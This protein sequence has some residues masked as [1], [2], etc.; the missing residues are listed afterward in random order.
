MISI[1]VKIDSRDATKRL[2]ATRDRAAPVMGQ[3]LSARAQ[4]MMAAS[5]RIAP[6][7]TR[8]LI[9]SARV[10]T[11]VVSGDSVTVTLGYGGAASKYAEVQH[12]KFPRKR[13]PGRT[14][15]YLLDPVVEQSRDL[16]ADISDRIAR[17]L[18]GS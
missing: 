15:H 9:Q 18:G 11:P 2:T 8:T 14:W 7:D 17:L 12:E 6:W 1:W 3:A 5:T 13:K 16:P 4:L 10:L